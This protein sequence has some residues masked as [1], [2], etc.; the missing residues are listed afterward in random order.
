[1]HNEDKESYKN[2]IE[3]NYQFKALYERDYKDALSFARDNGCNTLMLTGDGEAI[4]NRKFVEMVSSLNQQLD[5]PF[6]WIEL[7]TSGVYLT[8]KASNGGDINLRWLRDYI[9]VKTISLSLS[10]VWSSQENAEYNCPAKNAFVDIENTCREIKKY[11]F[12]LRLSLN[13]T[14][15]YNDK[16]PEEIF[17]RAE[18]LGANQITFRVLYN[19]ANPQDDKEK[20]INDW[21]NVHRCNVE[22]IRDC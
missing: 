19:V 5:S 6:R 20:E 12:N 1:M 8:K 13:M 16:S 21:I 14:D 4:L 17:R 11:D 3:E 2:Q 18:E 22:K 7:Q 10:S 9:R 15:F